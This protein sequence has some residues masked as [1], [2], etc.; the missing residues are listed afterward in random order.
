M[1]IRKGHPMVSIRIT[2]ERVSYSLELR[3]YLSHLQPLPIKKFARVGTTV[4][5]AIIPTTRKLA[6]NQSTP[7]VKERIIK[8]AYKTRGIRNSIAV[9]Q[10]ITL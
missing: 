7:L 5:K 9:M 2:M 10:A 4:S 6:V 8:I 1:T 3:W